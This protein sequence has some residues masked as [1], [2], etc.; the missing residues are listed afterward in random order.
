MAKI[1]FGLGE[2]QES[3]KFGDIVLVARDREVRA[4]LVV[5]APE[6]GRVSRG[7]GKAFFANL[8]TGDTRAINA[9]VDLNIGHDE[10]VELFKADHLDVLDGQEAVVTIS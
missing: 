4:Y 9:P 6:T 3:M 7:T 2:Q 5:L 10:L 8:E 1:Q